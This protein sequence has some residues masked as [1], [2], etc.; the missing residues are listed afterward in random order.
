VTASR[1]FRAPLGDHVERRLKLAMDVGER[2]VSA[3]LFLRFALKIV[4]SLALQPANVMALVAEGLVVAFMLFRRRTQDMSTRLQD[5]AVGLFGTAA[6][7]LAR[8]GGHPLAPVSVALMLMLGGFAF[9]IWGKLILRRSFGLA[10]AN[11]GVVRAGAYAFVRHPIYAG[12]ILIYCGFFL[13]NP[14]PPGRPWWN[15]AVYSVAIALHLARILAEERVLAADP[16]YAAYMKQVRYRL[17]P[18][19]F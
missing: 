2:G 1:F 4:P 9:S 12:Y 7:L 3:A 13:L 5:W 17:A 10:A 14:A 15:A 6:P 11:R 19:L 8:P 18:G 16:A